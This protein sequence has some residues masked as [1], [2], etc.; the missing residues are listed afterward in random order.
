[1]LTF[2]AGLTPAS[3]VSGAVGVVAAL[4]VPLF[5]FAGSHRADFVP[6]QAIESGRFDWLLNAVANARFYGPRHAAARRSL[7]T[8]PKGGNR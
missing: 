6:R 7:F 1:V 8:A 5:L 4:T 2:L 3:A